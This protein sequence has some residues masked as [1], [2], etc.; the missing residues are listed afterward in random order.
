MMYWERVGGC[1]E[2]FKNSVDP[3]MPCL[4]KLGQSNR[5]AHENLFAR[6]CVCKG[7]VTSAITVHFYLVLLRFL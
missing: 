6:S 4:Y 5:V 3:R 2:T 1:R 7:A